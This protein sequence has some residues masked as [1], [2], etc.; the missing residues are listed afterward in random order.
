MKRVEIPAIEPETQMGSSL[1]EEPDEE[2]PICY[3]EETPCLDDIA[4]ALEPQAT[5]TKRRR[6]CEDIPTC[7]VEEMPY[8]DEGSK[9]ACVV[10]MHHT[11]IVAMDKDKAEAKA[12]KE[13]SGEAVTNE[14]HAPL[15]RAT[16]LDLVFELRGQ[17]ADQE[18]KALLMG[19]CLDLLLNA[20]SNA[21]AN[22]KCPTCAQSFVI[23]AKSTCQEDESD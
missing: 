16:H 22:R 18:H 6:L 8:E 7:Y 12:G 19:H 10:M 14:L 1:K 21:P 3:V 11:D 20:Y 13:T 5:D 4:T 23:Q 2:F 17:M 15:L 9:R